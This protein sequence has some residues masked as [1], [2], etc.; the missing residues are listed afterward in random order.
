MRVL[1]LIC[2]GMAIL[3]LSPLF[4]LVIIVLRMTGEGEVFY[5]QRRVGLGQAEFS[6]LKFATMVKN[7]PNIGAGT[8]TLQNDSRVLPV[9]RV[10]RK[11]KINELPQLFNILRGDMGLVGPRPLVPSGDANYTEGAA[12]IIRSVRPGLTGMASLLLRDEEQFY[13]HR[14]DASEFYQAVIMPYKQA[15]ELEYIK[16]K[17]VLLDLKIIWLTA[18]AVLRPS[19]DFSVMFQNVPIMPREMRDNGER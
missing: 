4:L 3:L 12:Q 9:G 1:D 15:V 8:I 6:I 13:S 17:S 10:L 5:R 19:S 14:S 16:N 2:S 11:T 18:L 7:S